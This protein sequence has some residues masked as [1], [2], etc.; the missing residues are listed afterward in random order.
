MGRIASRVL[1]VGSGVL[2]VAAVLAFYAGAA[3]LDREGF[4]DRAV[5]A[6]AQDEVDEEIATRFTDGVVERSPGLVTLRPALEAAAA[7]VAA[8]PWFKGRFGAGMRAFHR[9]I[10]DSSEP[11]PALRVPEMAAQVRAAV[12]ERTP[13]LA[14]RLPR[15]AD[16][17]LLS[18]GGSGPERALLR[19]AR[20]ADAAA[21]VAPVLLVLGLLGL[22]AGA[23]VAPDRRR[24]L[25]GP[26]DTRRRRRRAHRGL[27]RR[28]HA[29]A[30]GLR[31]ELGRRGRDVDLGRLPRRPAR[32]EP[33][34]RRRRDHRRRRGRPARG[35]AVGAGAGR[36]P[37]RR[38]AGRGRAAARGPRRRARPRRR[39]CRRAAPLPGHGTAAGR[40]RAGSPCPRS[41]RW[42]SCVAVASGGPA[43]APA[44]TA[45]TTSAGAA[46]A[47]PSQRA[48]GR[49]QAKGEPPPAGPQ[50]CFASM[51][52]A[53]AA[54]ET[55]AI[56]VGA[57]VRRLADGRVCV[58]AR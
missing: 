11:R 46:T 53:R 40:P 13:V 27:D 34:A 35:R 44:L 58:R 20:R 10:F 32:L 2:L 9:D 48:A 33:R 57:T 16:P 17:A 12:A 4:A 7:D 36:G 39:R 14:T 8:G 22:V 19:G 49:R 31:H 50:V 51:Q 47:A 18:V 55:A 28:P 37:R 45:A 24:G 3:I 21:A 25:W 26:G 30:R 54:A 42:R 23:L 52:D 6:L 15:D 56:P 1:L 41:P 29:D 38:G 5:S 43:H